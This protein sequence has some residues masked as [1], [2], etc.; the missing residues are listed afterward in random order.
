[1]KLPCKTCRTPIPPDAVNFAE[2][3]CFCARCNEWFKIASFLTES[4]TIARTAKPDGTKVEFVAEADSFGL[5]IPAG[6]NRNPALFF[7]LSLIWISVVF[8]FSKSALPLGLLTVLFVLIGAVIFLAALYNFWG[9]FSLL[10]DR[11]EFR[12]SWSLFKW[13]YRKKYPTKEITAVREDV[14]YSKNYAPVYG[15]GIACGKKTLKFGSGLNE[16]ERK[17]LVGEIRHFL[18]LRG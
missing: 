10:I 5:S 17:W 8:A 1:M 13:S 14:V 7:L 11:E 16:D 6:K 9:Q 2:G 15:V 4:D 18:K 12:V 3:I